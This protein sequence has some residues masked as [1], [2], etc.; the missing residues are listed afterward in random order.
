MNP[1]SVFEPVEL[2]QKLTGL[3]STK[4]ILGIFPLTSMVTT[5]CPELSSLISVLS[6]S[7]FTSF[8]SRVE[9]VIVDSVGFLTEMINPSPLERFISDADFVIFFTTAHFSMIGGL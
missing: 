8:T 2:V 7:S 3:P 1:I 5:C 9:F 6:E 4:T